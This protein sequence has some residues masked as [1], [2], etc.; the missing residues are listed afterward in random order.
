MN[1]QEHNF[2]GLRINGFLML[3]I[4]FLLAVLIVWL[5]SYADS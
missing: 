4:D 1:T 2:S 5:F 3:F